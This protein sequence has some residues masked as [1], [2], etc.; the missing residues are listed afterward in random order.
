MSPGVRKA[1]LLVHIIA[2]VGSI[3]AV[4]AFIGL[5]VA[6]LANAD[7]GFARAAY[8]AME[9]TA[10]FAIVPLIGASLVTGIVE[11]LGTTW[12]LFRY[13][14]VATKLGL[15]VFSMIVLLIHMQPIGDLAEAAANPALSLSD[16]QSLQVQMLAAAIAGLLVLIVMTVLSVYKPKGVTRYGWRV[17]R[18][19]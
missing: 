9:A 3:G 2:S 14:W 1:A 18:R 5:A 8:P 16:Y 13:Y 4:A 19:A 17:Q 15:T 11:S 10:W 12:G 6:A 7:T